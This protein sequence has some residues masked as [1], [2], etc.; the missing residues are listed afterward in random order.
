MLKIR[1][2][3]FI[4]IVT[5]SLFQSTYSYSMNEEN[6]LEKIISSCRLSLNK[7]FNNKIENINVHLKIINSINNFNEI[8]KYAESHEMSSLAAAKYLE[9]IAN[10]TKNPIGRY[11]YIYRAALL[12][13]NYD[14]IKAHNLAFIF[15]SEL[16]QYDV[17]GTHAFAVRCFLED[18]E[19][20]YICMKWICF[21]NKHLLIQS[22]YKLNNGV[23]KRRMI[24]R[25]NSEPPR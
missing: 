11:R 8:G 12:Y 23:R 7:D 5:I 2:N 25:R 22:I 3:P 21:L 16:S 4:L 20:K 19:V 17:Y 1:S 15:I 14:K 13:S 6:D 9:E 10:T 18:F 24:K